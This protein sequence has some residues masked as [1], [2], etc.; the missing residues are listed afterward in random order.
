MYVGIKYILKLKANSSKNA[1]NVLYEVKVKISW[2]DPEIAFQ[3]V[4]V[5]VSCL[6]IHLISSYDK[7]QLVHSSSLCKRVFAVHYLRKFS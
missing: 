1:V 7:R 3:L 5:Y 2:P 6:R 4:K